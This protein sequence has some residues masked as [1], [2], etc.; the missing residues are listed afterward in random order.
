M[1]GLSQARWLTW[2]NLLTSFRLLAAPPLFLSIEAGAWS[3][4]C[5]LF[6]LAVATD[7]ID[8]RVARARG[9]SSALGGLLDHATDAVFVMAGLFA[10]GRAGQVPIV[11]PLFVGAAFVQYMVDS[12]TLA[13]QPLRTSILGRWNGI[14]YF[15]P[16]GIVVTRG[17]LGWNTPADGL[18]LTVGWALVASTVVSMA[19][20][21]WALAV[22]QRDGD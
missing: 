4:A 13:G 11:L 1:A 7:W 21:G 19:D 5:T 2:A 16:V 17:L 14:L 22:S 6:W 12:K 10:L 18:V 8:G 15:V 3:V 9:E 20:R